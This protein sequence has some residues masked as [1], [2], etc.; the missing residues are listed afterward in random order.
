MYMPHAYSQRMKTT[1]EKIPLFINED[2]EREFWSKNSPLDYMG[3][4]PVE[5]INN[6]LLA[7]IMRLIR[8]Q[9]NYDSNTV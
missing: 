1:H 4:N 5:A 8:A 2:Q 7:R 9:G 3:I 6:S